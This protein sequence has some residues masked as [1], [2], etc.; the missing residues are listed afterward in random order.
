MPRIISALLA[1]AVVGG[2]A[3]GD[4]TA[5]SNHSIR[6][7]ASATADQSSAGSPLVEIAYEKWILAGGVM[8]GNTSYGPGTFTGQLLSRVAFDN[9]VVVKLQARYVVT[10]PTAAGRSFTALVEG[11]L[12][13]EQNSA[14][15]NGVVTDGWRVGSPVHVAFDVLRPCT[16][17]SAPTGIAAC[18]QGTIRVGPQQ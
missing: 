16:V 8:K 11:T 9:G 7:A 4:V 3:G 5:P 12:N 6:A 13:N 1:L 15:L 17:P 18:F 2:C 14:V 10:D